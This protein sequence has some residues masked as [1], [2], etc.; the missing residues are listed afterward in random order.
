MIS[1]AQLRA[2]I[3]KYKFDFQFMEYSIIWAILLFWYTS[4]WWWWWIYLFECHTATTV[5]QYSVKPKTKNKESKK[6][7]Q[8]S[9]CLDSLLP[10]T[11]CKQKRMKKKQKKNEPSEWVIRRFRFVDI[12]RVHFAWVFF[13][14]IHHICFCMI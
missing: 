6:C 9:K 2:A 14:S 13:L 3:R 7:K 5:R 1:W 10:S 8:Y 11:Q 4:K 12:Y